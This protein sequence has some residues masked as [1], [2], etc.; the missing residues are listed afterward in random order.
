MKA[1]KYQPQA[2]SSLSLSL[3]LMTCVVLISELSREGTGAR[4]SFEKKE[5]GSGDGRSFL[6]L[7][8]HPGAIVALPRFSD[9]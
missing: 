7:S 6:G 9:S 2:T 8:R 5:S 3:C 4:S 1:N